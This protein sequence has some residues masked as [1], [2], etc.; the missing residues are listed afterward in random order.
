MILQVLTMI[1]HKFDVIY[2]NS[3]TEL[4]NQNFKRIY[5]GVKSVWDSLLVDRCII[6]IDVFNSRLFNL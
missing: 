1:S 5:A 2:D 3:P 6:R 4:F